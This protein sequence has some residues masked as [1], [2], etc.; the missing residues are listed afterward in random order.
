MIRE[1]LQE[2]VV[3]PAPA[4]VTGREFYLPHRAV[5]RQSAETT[6]LRVGYDASARAQEKAP[7]LNECL[8]A[9]PPLHNK[10][11][12]VIA[13]NRFHSVA[14]AGDLRRAFLQVR[15]RESERDAL[16]FYWIADKT[17]KQVETLRFT[18]VV[19]G[20][21][22]SPFLLNGVIQQHLEYLQSRYPDSVNEIRRSLYVDDLNSGGPTS[23]KA[24]RL[25]RGATEIFAVAN[26]ELHKW[27]SNE[28]QLETSCEDYEPSFAKEQLENGTAA[29]ECKLLGLGW[30]KVQ[31]TLQVSFHEQ[32]AEET[33]RGIL[34]NLTKVYDPLG[35]VSPVMLEGKVLYRESCIQKNAWDPPL[36]EQ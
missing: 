14:V 36:S 28:D 9:G 1:K 33:N 8:H 16:R 32:P 4:E 31:D 5:V 20:L 23:E 2:G 21:A 15:I 34:A 12:S 35:I 11:W 22:P 24:K 30:D 13:R 17:G 27:H 18:R 6:K 7:S 29:G 3:E 10:L 25:K 26:F 19:F